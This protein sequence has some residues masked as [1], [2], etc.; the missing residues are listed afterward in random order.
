MVEAPRPDLQIPVFY[1]ASRT[2]DRP[3]VLL[4]LM[5]M[6]TEWIGWVDPGVPV[7]AFFPNRPG[8]RIGVG[9]PTLEKDG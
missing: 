5:V 7:S 6:A 4:K 9:L 8:D 3:Q 1:N 2:L